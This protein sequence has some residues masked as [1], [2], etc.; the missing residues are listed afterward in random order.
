M[1]RI[2]IFTGKGGVGKTSV[3]AA[4]AR[5]S[6]LEGKKTLIVSTD[7]AHNLS[8]IFGVS[9]GKTI[10]RVEE[11][12]F[13][14]EI[15]PNHMMENEFGDMKD[16]LIQMIKS[17]GAPIS[18]VD[19][20]SIFPGV[21]ELFSLLKILEIYEAGD[22]ERIIV[23]C[24]PTGETI[25]LLKIP[26]LLSWYMEKFLPVGKVALR[27]L[28]PISKAA[29]KIELPNKA[30]ISDVERM[31]LK[32]EALQALFKNRE[33][34]SIR[35]VAI[36]EKM[37]VEETKRNYMYMNLYNFQVDGLYINRILP[38]DIDNPFFNEWIEIQHQY[39]EEYEMIFGEIPIYKIPWFDRDLNGLVGIDLIVKEVLKT[40]D[41]FGVIKDIQGETYEKVKGGYI[42]KLNLPCVEKADVK[43]HESLTDIIIKI[44]NFKR[45]IPKPSTLRNHEIAN[46]KFD[47]GILTITL[48]EK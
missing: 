2:L 8:D 40:R 13:A 5:H 20:L 19:H 34:T 43:L 32:L 1:S 35:I 3:A 7:M 12:L 30:A 11:N 27:V 4:H 28:A 25:A 9:L 41:V 38:S 48:L 33:V 17:S 18:N 42:L 29:F 46:A 23:D 26:E 16:A 44:G 37:V 14:L 6:S 15:D 45:N 24:A 39:I 36:P 31:F 21:D 47:E 10:C 22:F